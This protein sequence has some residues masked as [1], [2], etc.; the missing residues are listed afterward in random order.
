MEVGE[1][2]AHV[3]HGHR[4]AEVESGRRQAAEQGERFDVDRDRLQAGP[5]DRL[6]P[7]V[8]HFVGRR[9]EQHVQLQ[10]LA[11]LAQH[12]V[13]DRAL[14]D[15]GQI[16]RCLEPDGFRQRIGRDVGHPDLAHRDRRA[17][18]GGDRLPRRDIAL[19]QE[20]A[21]RIRHPV[22]FVHDPLTHRIGRGRRDASGRDRPPSPPALQVDGFEM[23]APDIEPDDTATA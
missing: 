16:L 19:P 7:A 9:D 4:L 11:A 20:R 23:T 15:R 5:F 14:L 3:E 2:G 21:D 22:R 1:G 10:R 13:L 12:V 18:D 8:N 6:D 17:G